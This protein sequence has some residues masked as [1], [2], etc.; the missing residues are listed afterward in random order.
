M[1]DVKK[2]KAWLNSLVFKLT[3]V[4]TTKPFDSYGVTN[5]VDWAEEQG[6]DPHDFD[7][8]YEGKVN[9]VGNWQLDTGERIKVP[10]GKPIKDKQ[11]HWEMVKKVP[12][13]E[14]VA[15]VAYWNE[16]CNKRYTK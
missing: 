14:V 5:I 10:N 11:S 2:S 7:K 6:L 4:E 15:G 12:P 3:E 1:S 8:L 16:P 9:T 13:T